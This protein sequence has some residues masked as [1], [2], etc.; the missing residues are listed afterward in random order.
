[1][2][3][4]G[5]L[6]QRAWAC[7][8]HTIPSRADGVGVPRSLHAELPQIFGRSHM[9]GR[10]DLCLLPCGKMAGFQP[11][12]KSC[13]K[14]HGLAKSHRSLRLVCR[15]SEANW[16]N[17]G[18]ASSYPHNK[19]L[20]LSRTSFPSAQDTRVRTRLQALAGPLLKRLLGRKGP[21]TNRQEDL[22]LEELL[23][24]LNQRI[25][26]LNN[27]LKSIEPGRG[28]EGSTSKGVQLL[29]SVS[30]PPSLLLKNSDA[31]AERGSTSVG[32]AVAERGNTPVGGTEKNIG[33][34][35]EEEPG[36]SALTTML[37]DYSMMV[38]SIWAMNGTIKQQVRRLGGNT[39]IFIKSLYLFWVNQI[40]QPFRPSGVCWRRLH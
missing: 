22:Q 16:H 13:L 6:L 27:Q 35:D 2:A 32:G 1:M 19:P 39:E 12:Q 9:Q 30:V 38:A 11:L 18:R 3:G 29:K 8:P 14:Q 34:Q 17:D 24:G 33:S 20:P 40:R 28:S 15:R 36:P 5:V 10:L 23:D 26:D 7:S 25:T 4:T 21:A 37:V 31:V